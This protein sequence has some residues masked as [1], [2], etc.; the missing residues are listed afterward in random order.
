VRAIWILAALCFATFVLHLVVGQKILNVGSFSIAFLQDG[1]LWRVVTGNLLHGKP[2]FPLHLVLNMLALLALGNLVERILG[3]ARVACVIGVAGV[4]AMLAGGVEKPGMLVGASGIVFGLAGASLWLEFNCAERLPAWL[5][6]PRRSMFFFLAVN[7]LL[8]FSIPF[9]SGG[10]HIGGF[11]GGLGATAVLTGPQL[12]RVRAP[13]PVQFA[14]ALVGVVTV[15]AIGAA[16]W[17]VFGRGNFNARFN[18]RLASL[19]NIAPVDLHNRAWEIAVDPKSTYQ[20]LQA[21]LKMAERAVLETKRLY[22]KPLDTLAEVQ[23]RLGQPE[24][25][26]ETILEAIRRDPRDP[27]FQEQLRRFSGERNPADRPEG[28]PFFPS[29]PDRKPHSKPELGLTV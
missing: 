7:G 17:D 20:D 5:R 2:E 4:C 19:P 9:V 8:M 18:T 1:D 13:V 29:S 6:I 28:G 14:A 10:A 27:H 3:P 25:A 22:P 26:R 21:A 16:G 15:A 24:L 12:G 23:Y 11:L